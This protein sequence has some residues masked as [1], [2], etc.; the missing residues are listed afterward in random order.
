M[1]NFVFSADEN[2]ANSPGEGK[3]AIKPAIHSFYLSKRERQGCDIFAFIAALE[4]LFVAVRGENGALK[5]YGLS[6]RTENNPA[7]I[8]WQ[9]DYP[10][11]ICAAG[12]FTDGE[13]VT[14]EFYK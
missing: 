8:A 11:P 7:Y 1:F 4:P 9:Y 14:L 3:L 13:R 12:D 10:G 2:D 5:I 6:N